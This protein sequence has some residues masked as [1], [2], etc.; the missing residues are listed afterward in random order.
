M[1]VIFVRQFVHLAT[2]FFSAIGV[3]HV[4]AELLVSDEPVVNTQEISLL[5]FL[6]ERIRDVVIVISWLLPGTVPVASSFLY[7][8]VGHRQEIHRV[9]EKFLI[10]HCS[11][12]KEVPARAAD[13]ADVPVR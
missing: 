8:V 10:L 9:L 2:H 12:S 3:K 11:F 7:V 1:R 13:N 4:L 5:A 6:L